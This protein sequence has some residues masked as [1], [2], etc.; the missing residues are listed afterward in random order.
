MDAKGRITVEVGKSFGQERPVLWLLPSRSTD[1]DLL[2]APYTAQVWDAIRT[3]PTECLSTFEKAAVSLCCDVLRPRPMVVML[4]QS[5][6]PPP[7]NGQTLG[8]A[9]TDEKKAIKKGG[10]ASTAKLGCVPHVNLPT[11]LRGS[12]SLTAF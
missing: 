1:S 4:S 5:P 6:D 2:L 11:V 8:K 12:C 10:F 7:H 9:A 3:E